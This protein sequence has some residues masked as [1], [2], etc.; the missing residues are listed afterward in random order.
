MVTWHVEDVRRWILP[1]PRYLGLGWAATWHIVGAVDDGEVSCGGLDSPGGWR[2]RVHAHARWCGGR[3]SSFVAIEEA[4]DGA[5]LGGG[6]V[7]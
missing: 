1:S 3:W 2:F 4:L 5:Q 6:D 7:G